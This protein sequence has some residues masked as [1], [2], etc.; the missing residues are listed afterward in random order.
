MSIYF[1]GGAGTVTGS[2]FLVDAGRRRV[3]IDCGLFQG[4]KELRL[5]NWADFPVDPPSIHALI[6]THAHLDHCGAL[7]LLARGGFDGPIF[8]TPPTADL[9][10]L[11]LVDAARIEEEEAATANEMGY[12]KHRPARPLFT[13]KEARAALKQ[14]ATLQLGMWKEIGEGIRFRLRPSGHILGSAL[15]ELDVEGHRILFT[16]DLGR[17]KPLIYPPPE[18]V[19]RADTLVIESTYGDRRHVR[20]L[21]L[22]TLAR[23]VDEVTGRRGHLIIPSFAVGRAQELLYLLSQLKRMNRIPN[24]PIYLDSP[25]AIQATEIFLSHS[26]WH[27]LSPA[28]CRALDSAAVMVRSAQQSEEVLHKRKSSIVIAGSGMLTGGRVLRHLEERLGDRRNCILLTGYQAAG[29]RGRLLRE[30]APEI[31]MHGEYY[32]VAAEVREMTALSAHADQEEILRWLRGFKRPPRQTLIV[33]GEPQASDTLR[34]KLRDTLGWVCHVP[35][36]MEKIE[37]Q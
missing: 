16:G 12:S 21:P 27:R 25:M 17:Q 31:K 35:Q 24:L 30:G 26:S 23:V 9:A 6:L 14:A 10:R 29:T 28:E 3:L 34:M 33:H 36:A 19:D 7:P 5:R 13:E 37:I 2:K 18:T 8:C 22:H 20:E 15:V 1:L 32:P 11:V 4:L